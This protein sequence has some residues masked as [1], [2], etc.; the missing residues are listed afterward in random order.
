MA[1]TEQPLVTDAHALGMLEHMAS[2]VPT[3]NEG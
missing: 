2:L 3:N 1:G